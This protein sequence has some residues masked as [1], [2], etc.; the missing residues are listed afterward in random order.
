MSLPS[1][2]D[3]RRRE[4][5]SGFHFYNL[6]R[7]S[8]AAWLFKYIFGLRPAHPKPPLIFGGVMHEAMEYYYA[9]ECDVEIA[10]EGFRASLLL[11]HNEYEE[12]VKYQEDLARGPGMIQKF[13]EEIGCRDLET[14]EVLELETQYDIPLGPPDNPMLFTVRPDRIFR[15][16]LTHVVTPMEMKTTGWSLD[17]MFKKTERSDQVTSYIWAVAKKHPEWNVDGC[18]ID[19]LYSRRLKSGA[20]NHEA[21]RPGKAFRSKYDL[22]LFEMGMYG[23]IIELT[24]KVLALGMTPWPLLFPVTHNDEFETEYEMLFKS[25][26]QPDDPPPPGFVKDDWKQEMDAIVKKTQTFNLDQFKYELKVA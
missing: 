25:P 19:V 10:I 6:Y 18:H 9:A 26:I 3:S 21:K 1:F 12:E 5:P 8:P 11:R 15:N 23:T 16:R 13:H 17:G 2:P 4:S 14:Y 20:F 22:V 24:Q 7:S